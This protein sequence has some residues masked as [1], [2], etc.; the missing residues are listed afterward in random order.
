[1]NAAA[2]AV[3]S[4]ELLVPVTGDCGRLLGES[5][6]RCKSAPLRGKTARGAAALAVGALSCSAQA[7]FCAPSVASPEL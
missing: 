3:S 6:G 4:F 5:G 7:R 1:M 2:S